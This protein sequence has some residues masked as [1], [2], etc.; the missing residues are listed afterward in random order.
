MSSQS[1]RLWRINRLDFGLQYFPETLLSLLLLSL[2]S[3]PPFLPLS[4]AADLTCH[5]PPPIVSTPPPT[6]V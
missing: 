6:A 1:E 2:D 5:H 4:P 3:R